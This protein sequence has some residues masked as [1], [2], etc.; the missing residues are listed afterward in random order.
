MD[1]G[2]ET[3]LEESDLRVAEISLISNL[4][5]VETL[6]KA[7]PE[8]K[9]LLVIASMGY[10]SYAFGFLEDSLPNRATAIYLRARSYGIRALKLN[11]NFEKYEKAN[12]D[13]FTNGL[14]SIDKDNLDALFWTAYNWGSVI[15]LNLNDPEIISDLSKVNAMMER[16]IKIDPNYY[17]GGAY[18]YLGSI[19]SKIPKMLGG[20]PEKSKEYF[21][22]ALKISDG[23]F[24]L[25]YV[26][27][28]KMYAVAIQDRDLFSNLLN[29]VIDAD[30]NILP[31]QI[32]PNS[33]A[34]DKAS[35]LLVAIDNYF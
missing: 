30:I 22:K 4:K 31:S 35:K 16:V 26:Y 15:N 17:Y 24:L 12:L 7:D 6:I 5:L 32:L 10:G 20:N 27:Y 2:L 8:N 3:L 23:K 18:L 1:Y 9:K 21:E 11:T 28:A 13:D 25:T 33:I 34:K 29:K 14:N 19:Y